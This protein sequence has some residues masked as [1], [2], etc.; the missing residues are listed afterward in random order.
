ML[1]FG[2]I[3][4]NVDNYKELTDCALRMFPIVTSESV[5]D[6]DYR[7]NSN[8]GDYCYYNVSNMY[9][10]VGYFEGEYYRFGVVFIYSNGTLSNVYNTLGYNFVNTQPTYNKG[11]IYNTKGD[12]IKRIYIDMDDEGWIVDSNSIY[13]ND[14]IYPNAKGVLK[15]DTDPSNNT[16]INKIVFKVYKEV[17]DHL[18]TLNISGMFFVRQKRVPTIIA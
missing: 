2:N 8:G 6:I 15:I 14:N 3:V 4:K 16:K 18:K 10:K 17:I 7:Y 9:N 5:S 1:F 11:N 12:V 13:S